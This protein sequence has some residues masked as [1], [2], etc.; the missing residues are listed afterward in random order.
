MGTLLI[1][2][3]S[4]LFFSAPFWEG[5]KGSGGK[6]FDKRGEDVRCI[7]GVNQ[8]T[9]LWASARWYGMAPSS[10][11]AILSMSAW[12]SR[13]NTQ[14]A[15]EGV[16]PGK[17]REP[18]ILLWAAASDVRFSTD[19]LL[20]LTWSYCNFNFSLYKPQTNK[21]GP[22]PVA[23]TSKWKCFVTQCLRHKYSPLAWRF[24]KFVFMLYVCLVNQP[25]EQLLLNR[26]SNNFIF[27]ANK[28]SSNIFKKRRFV[29]M[30]WIHIL[31]LRSSSRTYLGD[32][33][34]GKSKVCTQINLCL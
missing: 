26:I 1:Q 6:G 5:S 4:I 19:L 18:S 23:S 11:G 3:L 14:G 21:A 13:L 15:R 9:C 33:I 27:T 31:D 32:C 28:Q 29:W 12:F 7:S 16:R 20:A 24:I 25:V 30:F 17:S 10:S 34:N 22:A 2:C 8:G